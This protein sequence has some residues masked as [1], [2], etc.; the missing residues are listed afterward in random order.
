[1]AQDL[2]PPIKLRTLASGRVRRVLIP[3][4][5]MITGHLQSVS[6][7]APSTLA[8]LRA[9]LIA[10]TGADLVCPVTLRHLVIQMDDTGRAALSLTASSP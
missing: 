2:A 3:T 6:P 4:Q 9:D 5:A 10:R 8:A 7:G 1:M